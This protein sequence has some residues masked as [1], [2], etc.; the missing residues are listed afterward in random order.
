MRIH[1]ATP[2]AIARNERHA[3]PAGAPACARPVIRRRSL[4]PWV[5]VSLRST[6]GATELPTFAFL[7]PVGTR[8]RSFHVKHGALHCTTGAWAGACGTA[9]WELHSGWQP[10][11]RRYSGLKMS[12]AVSDPS[13]NHRWS[14]TATIP[15]HGRAG[16]A[17]CPCTHTHTEAV[18]MQ[19]HA[20]WRTKTCL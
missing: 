19:K 10:G 1:D 13:G 6:I 9:A 3:F 4:T 2:V 18:R 12:A 17:Q 15:C 16:Q 11:H 20:S 5:R 14:G 8:I 7:G